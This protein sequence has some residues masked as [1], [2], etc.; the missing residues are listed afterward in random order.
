MNI[1]IVNYNTSTLVTALLG[2]I[3]KFVQSETHIYIFDNSDKE[4]CYTTMEPNVT[5]FDNTHGKILNFDTELKKYPSRLVSS[6]KH[7]KYA[8]AKHCMT[9]EK[10]IELIDDNVILLD[11][12]VLLK[13]DIST[14]YDDTCAVIA[15]Y[16]SLK[17]SKPRMLP[18]VEFLNVKM[19]R[20][21]GIHYFDCKRM[22]GL[23]ERNTDEDRY[24]TG[25]S[26][27]ED[28]IAKNLPYKSICHTDYIVHLKAGSW[29]RNR[30]Y[31]LNNFLRKY[32]D[33]FDGETIPLVQ[34]VPQVKQRLVRNP[35]SYN[36]C[37]RKVVYKTVRK[38]SNISPL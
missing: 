22:H 35:Y 18:Y 11:S 33:L 15:D 3:K 1:G 10:L 8:S 7:N 23:H 20:E 34:T 14:L 21:H 12:D 4:S 6:G 16:E 5:V 28:V 29:K 32:R 31:Y 19:L 24:D 37:A 30:E 36:P 26:L 17:G 25:A 38:K 9:V 2:S 13:C 27:Y